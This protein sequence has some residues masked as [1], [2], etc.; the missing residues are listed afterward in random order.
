MKAGAVPQ[1]N[2]GERPRGYGKFACNGNPVFNH[3]YCACGARPCVTPRSQGGGQGA[4]G[5][6]K[7]ALR[8]KLG[9]ASRLGHARDLAGAQWLMLHSRSA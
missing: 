2:N 5:L 1:R 6:Q 4:L 9:R 7:M 3:E 8:G